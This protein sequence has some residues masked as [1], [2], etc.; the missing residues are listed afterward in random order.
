MSDEFAPVAF[1]PPESL[2]GTY[3]VIWLAR[4]G[5]RTTTQVAT[6]VRYIVQITPNRANALGQT[7]I[8]P[9]GWVAH[10]A[11]PRRQS[12]LRAGS[13]VVLVLDDG[14]K[15]LGTLTRLRGFR[16]AQADLPIAAWLEDWQ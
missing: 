2:T 6:G 11:V 10:L 5:K 16:T 12:F 7:T 4:D 8:L 3:G 1:F 9:P 14:R 15:A 13:E